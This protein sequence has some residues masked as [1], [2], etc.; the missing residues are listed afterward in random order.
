MKQNLSISVLG[1][2]SFGTAV[3][4]IA[5]ENG[6]EVVLWMRDEESA[7]QLNRDHVNEKYLPGMPLNESVKATT[8]L[9]HAVT[10]ADILLVAIPSHAFRQVIQQCKPFLR[11]ETDLVS[12]TKGIERETFSLM[13]EVL[14]EE[15]HSHRIGVLSGPNLAKEMLQKMPTA[16][17]IASNDEALCRRIQQTL[18]SSYF[19]IYANTDTY[20]V[21][22]GGALKNIY[23]IAT[24]MAEAFG[25]GQN[26][27]SL[28]ITRA[29]AEMSRFAHT[30]GA[31]PMTFLGLSGVGDLVVSCSSNL[32][33]NFRIGFSM[34]QGKTL[35]QAIEELGQTAEGVNTIRLVK[36]K[37]DE[38]G[39]Y[40]PL[41]S[42]LNDLLFEAKSLDEVVSRLMLG[43]HSYDVDFVL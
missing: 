13:S 4:N 6:H 39:V 41:V 32:S 26:T 24:G 38:L 36:A 8:N 35:D 28:L 37:A 30:L 3:A 27:K 21:E 31:N 11:K 17:V 16:T 43:E 25:T 10:R 40:M 9:E 33:R 12:T 18:S 5:T 7:E 19:R 29:L 20:G 14:H 1:G 42:G 15:T 22:L 23:A 34:G 2:G